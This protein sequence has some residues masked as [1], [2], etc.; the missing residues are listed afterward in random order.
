[1]PSDREIGYAKPTLQ[2]HDFGKTKMDCIMLV[3][4][5]TGN[6]S[7]QPLGLSPTY[8]FDH[9][10][11][12]LRLSY[13]FISQATLRI[14]VGTFLG[15]NVVVDQATSLVTVN[16][17]TAHVDTL[18]AIPLTAT[19]FVPSAEF[20]KISTPITLLSAV[21]RGSTLSTVAPIYPE[22]ARMRHVGGSVVLSAIIGRDGR[23]HSLK[24]LSTPDEALSNSAL[25]A[26][27]QWTYKPYLLN[28]EPVEVDTIITVNF[29]SSR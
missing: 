20:E 16:E 28:G 2:E 24:V 9:D 7:S 29:F 25:A 8:C 18:E 10:Q 19:D 12:L 17:V 5:E 13:E 26:V 1:M 23:I 22:G 3:S 14:R 15:H 6:V 21:T 11:D 4:P 27:K